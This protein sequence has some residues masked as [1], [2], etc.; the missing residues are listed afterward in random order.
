MSPSPKSMFQM[1]MHL[2]REEIVMFSCIA[3]FCSEEMDY[4]DTCI[5]WGLN[6]FKWPFG[7]AVENVRGEC[8]H[9]LR[10]CR[11]ISGWLAV[12]EVNDKAL[13]KK[14]LSRN[15]FLK[16][17]E[18]TMRKRYQKNEKGKRHKMKGKKK[19]AK[20]VRKKYVHY[21]QEQLEELSSWVDSA[22]DSFMADLQWQWVSWVH[23]Y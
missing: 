19:K 3:K 21:L 17:L 20:R 4:H 11:D 5:V 23:G 18:E 14:M 7:R 15:I 13:L 22:Y 8:D 9:I 1:T 10:V 16:L 12:Q 2:S 6:S